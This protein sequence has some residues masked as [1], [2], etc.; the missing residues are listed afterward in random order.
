M[1][2][3]QDLSWDYNQ[4]SIGSAVCRVYFQGLSFMFQVVT[5]CWQGNSAPLQMDFSIG[6]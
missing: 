3:A 5:S 1:V 2:L 4:M 6:S